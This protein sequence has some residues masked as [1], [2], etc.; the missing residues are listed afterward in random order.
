[1]TS[2]SGRS[3]SPFPKCDY[4]SDRKAAN[5]LCRHIEWLLVN[6]IDEA[7]ARGNEFAADILRGSFV[8]RN[9]TKTPQD[10]IDTAHDYLFGLQ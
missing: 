6:A 7:V 10:A 4:T 1:L 3:T 5:S 2:Y 8:T 9:P